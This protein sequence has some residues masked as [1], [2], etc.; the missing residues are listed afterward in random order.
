MITPTNYIDSLKEAL[1]KA[2]VSPLK[3]KA[4]FATICG[5][6]R[7]KMMSSFNHW[8]LTGDDDHYQYMRFC[9][10]IVKELEAIAL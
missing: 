1:D 6:W 3:R 4:I 8:R 10:Q 2:N 7:D 9:E 5:Q